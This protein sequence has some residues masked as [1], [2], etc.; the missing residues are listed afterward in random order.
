M[1]DLPAWLGPLIRL[2]DCKDGAEKYVDYVFSFFKRDFIDSVPAFRGKHVGFD[3]TDDN[4][5]PAGF[6]HITTE[7]DHKT[8]ER[9]LSM[10][11]CERIGWIRAI[12]EHSTDPAVLMWEK[13]HFTPRRVTNR[14]YLFLECDNFVVIIE[15][16]K[17]G[18]YMITAIFVDSPKQKAKHL[19]AHEEYHQA[20]K[21]AEKQETARKGGSRARFTVGK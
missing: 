6:T 15:E 3:R 21:E 17:K 7:T 20:K 12:I 11:R 9:V 18:Y 13:E 1:A 2:E 16:K 10:R 19:K 5:K 8:G 4:G 14:I